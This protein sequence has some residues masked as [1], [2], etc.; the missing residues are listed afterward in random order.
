MLPLIR[1]RRG[2]AVG[3]RLAT[4]GLLTGA[5]ASCTTT[6][7]RSRGDDAEVRLSGRLE[8]ETVVRKIDREVRHHYF[9]FG[10]VPYEPD[11][12]VAREL[13]LKPG[14][15]LANAK[16][17]NSFGVIDVLVFVGGAALSAGILPAIWT[18]RTTTIRGELVEA[19]EP[20]GKQDAEEAAPK[21][22][23]GPPAEVAAAAP[24][25]AKAATWIE[26]DEKLNVKGAEEACAKRD[27]RLPTRS[28]LKKN[29]ELLSQGGDVWTG[30][31]PGGEDDDGKRAVNE[32]D[33]HGDAAWSFN[34]SAGA[35][36]LKSGEERLGVV[37]LIGGPKAS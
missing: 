5:L 36:F 1:A 21:P 10:L 26:L 27:G 28:E 12:D 13:K 2:P 17:E 4:V 25:P 9:L 24:A 6:T 20:S 34:L 11:L 31:R 33:D 23:V 37:C 3:R 18:T 7:Y 30:D 22:L 8:G 14:Q 16:I 35:A 15:T 29:R 32:D 19:E